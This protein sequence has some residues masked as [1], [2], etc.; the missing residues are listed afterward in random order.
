[1]VK[2]NVIIEG[3]DPPFSV[4]VEAVGRTEYRTVFS[5][6]QQSFTLARCSDEN[7]AKEHCHLVGHCFV[8]ALTTL[9]KAQRA[10][11]TRLAAEVP[12]GMVL[13]SRKGKAKAASLEH[14]AKAILAT[15]DPSERQLLRTRTPKTQG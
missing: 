8:Q 3:D 1:M 12:R 11:A 2:S 9:L 5:V 6:G 15:L 10:S 7:E 14:V 4:K 13:T